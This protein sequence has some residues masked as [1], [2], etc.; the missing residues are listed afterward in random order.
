MYITLTFFF[1]AKTSPI[2]QPINQAQLPPQKILT[3]QYL[4]HYFFTFFLASIQYLLVHGQH[5]SHPP[6]ASHPA[7]S[8]HLSQLKFTKS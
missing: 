8:S 4:V 1:L 5:H 6:S 7:L 3:V 2:N